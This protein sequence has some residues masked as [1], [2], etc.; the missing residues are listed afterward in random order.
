M[1]GAYASQRS[2]AS[3]YAAEPQEG[4]EDCSGQGR[5]FPGRCDEAAR[6][7]AEPGQGIPAPEARRPPCAAHRQ[8]L[9]LQPLSSWERFYPLHSCGLQT[10]VPLFKGYFLPASSL[11]NLDQMSELSHEGV[12]DRSILRQGWHERHGCNN[13]HL[14]NSIVVCVIVQG[15]RERLQELGLNERASVPSLRLVLA[16]EAAAEAA[17]AAPCSA[18]KR[19]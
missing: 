18:A 1:L 19:M 9:P 4:K 5:C 16:A 2:H 3:M 7:H 6:P 13:V 10:V 11:E 12:Q 15:A 17:A 8:G 14:C